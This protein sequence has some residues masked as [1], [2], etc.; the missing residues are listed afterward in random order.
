MPKKTEVSLSDAELAAKVARIVE[1]RPMANEYSL[2]CKDVK[3]E[4]LARGKDEFKTEAG[5]LARIVR[6]PL[7]AWVTT[8]LQLALPKKVFELLC[9]RKPDTKKLNQ[10]LAATP[11]DKK[12]AACLVEAG[13]EKELEVLA[14]ETL[15]RVEL[16]VRA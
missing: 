9:P 13:E 11:E 12:L 5:H 16:A 14:A 4:L 10:R 1:I 7:K 15:A 2:L 3:Q 8:A 6:K